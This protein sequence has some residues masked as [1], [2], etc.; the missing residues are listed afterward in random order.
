MRPTVFTTMKDDTATRALRATTPVKSRV[1]AGARAGWLTFLVVAGLLVA[2]PATALADGPA[3]PVATSYVARLT[4]VPAGLDARVVNGDQSMWLRVAP[5]LDVT[6]LDYTG[7]PYLRFTRTGVDVNENSAMYF[8]NT[9]GVNPPASLTP[10]RPDWQPASGGRTYQWHDGRL[11]ALAAVALAPGT[12]FVGRWTIPMVIDGRRASLS[13]TVWHADDP[14]IVWFW[15]A[16]VIILCALA[17]WRV[18]DPSLDR[19]IARALAGAALVA[20]TVAALGSTLYGRPSVSVEQILELV[21]LLALIG[22]GAS[23]LVRR[24]SGAPL[25]GVVAVVATGVGIELIPT[26]LHGYVLLGVPAFVGRAAA[27]VCLGTGVSLV[28]FAFRVGDQA[29]AAPPSADEPPADELDEA[30][31]P[32]PEGVA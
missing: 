16:A 30:I 19:R 23:R 4:T 1:C 3:L 22:L 20:L 17:G 21:A 29:P 7:E 6:V 5:G 25:L 27:V 12:R 2:R 26:L 31:A 8:L 24:R 14:S 9:W 13:G 32:Q 18:R 15:P 11:H 28:P 10:P